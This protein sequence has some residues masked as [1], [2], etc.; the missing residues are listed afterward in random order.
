[1]HDTRKGAKSPRQKTFAAL[2]FCVN[3]SLYSKIFVLLV[4]LGLVS[5]CTARPVVEQFATGLNQPRGMAFDAAGNLF[6]AEAGAR[7]PDDPGRSQPEIN[8]SSRVLRIDTRRHVTIAVD[9]LPYTRYTSSGDVGAS[10][11]A[12]LNRALY[13]LTGEGY[14]DQLSRSVLRATPS[15]PPQRVVSLLNFA[16]DTTLLDYQQMAGGVPINPYAMTVAP[17]G[18][19][20][21]ITDGASGRVLRATLDGSVRVFAELPN[22]PPLTGLAFGPDGRLYFAMFSLLP[23]TPGSGEIW[24]ADSSGQLSLATSGLTMP[25]DVS[26]DATGA[27]YILEFSKGIQPDQLYAA[28]NGRLLRAERNGSP[29]I[30]LD[31]LDYPTAMVFSQA[32]DLYIAVGGAFTAPGQGAILKVPCRMLAAPAGCPGLHAQ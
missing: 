32:G 25:I 30:V 7:D 11:V 1:M 4:C 6:V 2:R 16:I 24:V 8:H 22:M 9:G 27:M 20:L 5:G 31:H 17:D 14:D 15:T 28:G 12:V 3:Q 29:T 21:Y 13:V 10:D 18:S 23:H 26:F 19:A